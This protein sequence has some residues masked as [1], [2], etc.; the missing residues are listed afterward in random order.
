[1][2]HPEVS[3][4]LRAA[5]QRLAV[6]FQRTPDEVLASLLVIPPA[7][8]ESPESLVAWVVG[9][10]FR[11]L[12]SDGERYL[13]LLSW[14]AT[15]HPADFGEFIFSQSSGR[16]YLGLSREDVV[17]R[18]RHHHARQIDGTQYWAIMN[19]DLETKR[20]FLARLLEFVGYRAAV[21]EFVCSAFGPPV[22][23]SRPRTLLVA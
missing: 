15:R 9:P 19:L 4:A 21:G 7:S 6:R 20:R 16:R 2:K 5:L 22:A 3:E 17:E 11:A 18:C 14:I 12:Y 23:A 1:M 8:P 13:A 10:E